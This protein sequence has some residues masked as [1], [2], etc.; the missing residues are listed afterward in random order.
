MKK[1][2]T[3]KTS[4]KQ[5]KNNKIPRIFLGN[6]LPRLCMKNTRF[7]LFGSRKNLEDVLTMLTRLRCYA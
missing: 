2:D 5:T 4:R 7:C 1:N 6:D 3:R